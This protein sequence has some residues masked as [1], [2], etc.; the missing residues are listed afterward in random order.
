MR[1]SDSLE[2]LSNQ[3]NQIKFS[4]IETGLSTSDQLKVNCVKDAKLTCM[5]HPH[6]LYVA[7]FLT[8]IKISD[9]H[10]YCFILN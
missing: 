7:E 1:S 6:T 2:C 10:N 8:Q 4:I 9:T 3:N 5:S